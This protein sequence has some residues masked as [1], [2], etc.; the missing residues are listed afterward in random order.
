[1]GSANWYELFPATCVQTLTCVSSN[2]NPICIRLEGIEVNSL[3][4]WHFEQMWLKD[5]GCRD[6]MVQTWDRSVLGS[7]MEVVV[8]KVGLVKKALY[9]GVGLLF[10]M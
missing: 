5:L 6:T 8:S 9:I 4:P 2:H 3:R 1:M 7:P 10:A